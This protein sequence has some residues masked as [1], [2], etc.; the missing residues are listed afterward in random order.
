[1]IGSWSILSAGRGNWVVAEKM[2]STEV[3]RHRAHVGWWLR[4]QLAFGGLF[5][6]Q[7][8]HCRAGHHHWA[9]PTPVGGGITRQA[10]SACGEVSLDLREANEPINTQLFTRQS[11]LK[12]FAILRRHTFGAD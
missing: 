10:C 9:Q 2:N 6:S 11:E 7:R 8:R 4:L 5:H 1:M 3:G 12:T